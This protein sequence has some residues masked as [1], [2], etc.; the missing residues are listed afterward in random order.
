MI[1][2]CSNLSSFGSLVISKPLNSTPLSPSK[3]LKFFRANVVP[4]IIEWSIVHIFNPV[5]IV[6]CT[7]D[8]LNREVCDFSHS[9]FMIRCNVVYFTWDA[10]LPYNFDRINDIIDMHKSSLN[11]CTT[12][13]MDRALFTLPQKSFKFGNELFWILIW[14]IDII[15]SNRFNVHLE[16]LYIG[17]YNHFSRCFGG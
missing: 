14:T 1:I 16:R 7:C 3:I 11:V 2:F 15:A 8:S 9:K 12:F 5:V 13:T 10:L 4:P 6:L 17:S